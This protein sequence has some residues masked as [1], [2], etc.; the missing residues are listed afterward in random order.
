[1]PGP[2]PSGYRW[3]DAPVSDLCGAVAH[4]PFGLAVVEAAICG[5]ALVLADI[6]TFRE[7]LLADV[8]VV[9][10]PLHTADAPRSNR[11]VGLSRR[12]SSPAR[13]VNQHHHRSRVAV[14]RCLTVKTEVN[15]TWQ[16]A[17]RRKW[18]LGLSQV[19][20]LAQQSGGA[21]HSGLQPGRGTTVSIYLP[22]GAANATASDAAEPG[23]EMTVAPRSQAVPFPNQS[24]SLGRL[25]QASTS[26]A[27]PQRF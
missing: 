18:P 25:P 6:P 9:A 24:P 14:V 1:M 20:G 22:T 8:L 11:H 2:V 12:L 10:L 3:I 21:A 26:F 19:Y 4:E 15:R 7:V 23:P 13:L 27:T 5:A 16:S 17:D